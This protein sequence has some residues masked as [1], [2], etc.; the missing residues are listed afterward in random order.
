[1]STTPSHTVDVA[2]IG[3]GL[4]GLTAAANA[5]RSGATVCLYDARSTLGGRARS[6]RAHGFSANHGAHALY[7]HGPGA[8]VLADLGVTVRGRAPTVP[9][10]AFWR[11]GAVAS[12]LRRSTLGG[13]G[14]LA[15][16][17]KGL[18]AGSIRANRGV[19][20]EAWVEQQPTEHRDL[21]R[22]TIRL[23]TFATDLTNVD[24]ADA[25][26][27]VRSG[28]RGVTYLDGGWQQLVDSLTA[29]AERSGMQISTSKV[30]SVSQRPDGTWTVASATDSV[31]ATSVVAAVG[32]AGDA[33][34][35]LRTSSDAL[36]SWAEAAE[37]IHAYC[38][39]VMLSAKAPRLAALHGLGTPTYWSNFSRSAEVSP[40]SSTLLCGVVYEPDRDERFAGAEREVLETQLDAWWPHWRSSIVE[41]IERRRLV[42]A[43]DRP[44]VNRPLASVV[45]PDLDGFYLAGDCVAEFG[46]LADAA[47]G[48]GAEAGRRAAAYCRRHSGNVVA[49]TT[50]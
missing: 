14:A 9:G 38:L 20:A 3:G 4:A 2:V 30:T 5:A 15:S 10:T 12:S 47:L 29:I 42:V 48:S 41:V 32:G 18:R 37:P 28:A 1:M 13:Y 43:H 39:D 6:D 27:Q 33:L 11:D 40:H 7:S 21:L 25:L 17:A 19:S 49:L 44:R 45:V 46:W 16:L 34:R 35:L 8:A 31:N 36:T 22:F 26:A 23:S 24:A 50:R